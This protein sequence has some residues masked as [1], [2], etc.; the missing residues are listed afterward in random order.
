MTIELK[1][2]LDDIEPEIWRRVAVPA[3]Y[4]LTELHAVIQGAMGWQDSH[5]HM[6]EFGD[7]RYEIPEDDELGSEPGVLDERAYKL[8][9]LVSKGDTFHYVYDFGDD[10]R[11]T[12]LVEDLRTGE[13]GPS[14]ICLDGARACP[15]ED[16]G[17][18]FGYP[19]FLNVLADPK[20]PDHDDTVEWARGFQPEAFSLSQANSL[21]AAVCAIY[22]ER[23][24]GFEGA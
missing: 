19:E 4:T 23:G 17:G 13:G 5:L 18:P 10:W 24:L 11:H 12:V 1:V 2:S 6:F 21:I 9:K 14:A 8:G 22:R 16:C 20:H 7:Q 15:P 3:A